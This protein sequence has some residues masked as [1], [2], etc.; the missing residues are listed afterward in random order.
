MFHGKSGLPYSR[1]TS[2]VQIVYLSS[3][4]INKPSISKRH[5]R[6]ANKLFRFCQSFQTHCTKQGGTHLLL[7]VILV[8]NVRVKAMV[9]FA[10]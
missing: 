5:A 10:H 2:L 9:W 3:E 1:S 4:S 7:D 6:I 8:V